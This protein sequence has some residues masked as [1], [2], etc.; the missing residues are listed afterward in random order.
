MRLVIAAA[1]PEVFP[2]DVA[3]NK[4]NIISSIQKAQEAKAAVLVLPDDC[5]MG[6]AG[7]LE[8]LPLL[9]EAAETAKAE[10]LAAAGSLTVYPFSAA[11]LRAEELPAAEREDLLCCCSDRPATAYSVMENEELCTTVS[12]DKGCVVAMATPLGASTTDFV[13]DGHCVLAQNGFILASGE[14]FVSAE[15]D[16]DSRR[17][18]KPVEATV[19]SQPKNPWMPLPDYIGRV[20]PLQ[21]AALA[22]RI[23]AAGCQKAIVG[24][25]GGLDSTL[26]L[27]VCV[28][29]MERLGRTPDHVIA[30]TMPCF[31][32]TGRTRSN[33]QALAEALGCDFREVDIKASIDQH[34]RDIGHAD[35]MRNN[36]YENA[37]AR[38]RTQVLMDIANDENALAVG[39]GDL[40]ESALGWCTYN[41]DHM[42]MYNVNA[43][44][45][46]TVIRLVLRDYAATCGNRTLAAAVRDVL[47]TPVSPELLPPKD[48]G[49]TQLTENIVG[50]Y[51][52]HDFFLYYFLKYGFSPRQLHALALDTLGATYDAA[53]IK[54]WL[55]VFFRRFFQSQFKRSCCPDGPAVLGLSLSPR[56]G[57]RLP[58][59]AVGTLWLDEIE[60]L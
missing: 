51:E 13:Y 3:R 8:T 10:I 44:L 23:Q 31:G 21:A 47:D 28:R 55:G 20:I 14:G 24:V 46:K 49:M 59:D 50:P 43:G 36:A 41:G 39:T 33:A 15:V 56:A 38:E 6:L 19:D 5:I 40:S 48:G 2:A 53:T 4:V 57:F 58:S 27:A 17:S 18:K 7:D 37:Q 60:T 29:A 26:T 16:F 12:A 42:C 32:T 30:V 25:S 35:D 11:A 1:A 22:R 9:R 54:H 52:L 34:L 45:P